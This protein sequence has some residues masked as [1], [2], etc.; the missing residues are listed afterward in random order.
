MVAA[1]MENIRMK[2]ETMNYTKF[3]E[4]IGDGVYASFDGYQI[5]LKTQRGGGFA[6]LTQAWDAIALE[7]EVF[8][9]LLAFAKTVGM[10]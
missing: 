9:E 8:R 3:Q 5:W 10:K 1:R 2:N 7:P 4:Y 6:G